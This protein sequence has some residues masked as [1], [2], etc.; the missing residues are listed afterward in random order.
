MLYMAQ[1][2][3]SLLPYW[4]FLLIHEKKGISSADSQASIA[5]YQSLLFDGG[6]QIYLVPDSKIIK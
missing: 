5:S 6:F 2:F 3:Y 4:S 1:L